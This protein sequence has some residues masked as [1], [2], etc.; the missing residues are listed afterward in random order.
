MCEDVPTV[1]RIG[2]EWP[3]PD[4]RTERELVT[5]IDGG[6]RLTTIVNPTAAFLL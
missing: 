3:G 6:A 2:R 5:T 1:C 4:V